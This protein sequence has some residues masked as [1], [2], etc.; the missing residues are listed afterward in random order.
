MG[1]D[2]VVRQFGI[3]HYDADSIR[4]NGCNTIKRSRSTQAGV[5][6]TATKAKRQDKNETPS[7]RLE[8]AVAKVMARQQRAKERQ[9]SRQK[10]AEAAQRPA[11]SS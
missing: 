10:E 1:T 5:G 11:N 6:K 2:A 7:G 3:V 8:K 4:W 9:E